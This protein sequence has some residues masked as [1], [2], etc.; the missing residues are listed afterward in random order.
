MKQFWNSKFEIR[1][2]PKVL[3]VVALALSLLMMPLFAHAQAQSKVWRIGFLVPGSRLASGESYYKEFLPGMRDLGYAEGKDFI[4]EWRFAD[5]KYERLPELA[6]ELV[7]L[8][9]DVIIASSSPAIRAAQQATTTIPI[10]FPSTGDPI[11]SGFVK[12][13]ARPGG[14]ITSVSNENA[15]VSAKLLEL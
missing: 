15:A 9:V 8:N 12:S 2:W 4:L 3:F 7:R 6:A 14:N 1:N 5:G 13:L 10:V 11:G